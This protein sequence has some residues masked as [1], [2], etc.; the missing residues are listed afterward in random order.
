MSE[1]PTSPHSTTEGPSDQSSAGYKTL[2]SVLTR[3]I[4]GYLFAGLLLLIGLLFI[5]PNEFQGSD[6]AF[7]KYVVVLAVIA[8]AYPV[9]RLLYIIGRL[10]CRPL[11]SFE[12]M[13]KKSFKEINDSE[14]GGG[15][16]LAGEQFFGIEAKAETSRKIF[17]H[18]MRPWMIMQYPDLY[19]GVYTRDNTLR[20]VAESSLGLVVILGGTLAASGHSIWRILLA[21]MT[22]AIL[23]YT[24]YRLRKKQTKT[25]IYTGY[26][27]TREEDQL[28]PG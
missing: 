5:F 20:I 12:E 16:P 6:L 26:V 9:G 4:F 24:S 3:D 19:Y 25:R 7:N 18:L 2:L 22:G 1:D 10:I 28:P 17:G 21:V 14:S 23:L 8:A 13:Y 27:V 15:L 11:T